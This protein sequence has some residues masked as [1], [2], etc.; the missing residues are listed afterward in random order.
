MLCLLVGPDRFQLLVQDSRGQ[1]IGLEDYT[2]ASLL[3]SRPLTAMLA[4]VFRGHALLTAGPWKE[5]RIGVNSS[6]FTLIPEPLYRKEYAGNYL[7]L[8]RGGTLPAHEFA[9][10]YAH[11]AEGFLSLFNLEHPLSDYFSEVY[12]LQPI[13]FVHQTSALIQ[14]TTRL[15]RRSL[16]PDALYLYFEH[17]FVTIIHRQAHQLHYCNRIG[18]RNGQD[19]AYYVLYVLDGQQLTPDSVHLSLFGEITLFSEAYMELSR[20]LPNMTFGQT[21]PGLSLS[22]EFNELPEHRYLSLYGLGLLDEA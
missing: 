11:E 16:A 22:P 3:D 21:P 10:A 9:H 8:M 2:F 6:L 17:A 7:A 12:P 19:L 14:A 15:D 5:I 20:F 1:A 18:Y 13:T 4:D